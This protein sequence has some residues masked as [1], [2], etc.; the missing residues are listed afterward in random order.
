MTEE[1]LR[2]KPSD[3]S[4]KAVS[5]DAN[6]TFCGSVFHSREVATGKSSIANGCKTG[7]SHDKQ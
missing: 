7:A 1:R 6:L 3:V 5:D 2:Y 4:K